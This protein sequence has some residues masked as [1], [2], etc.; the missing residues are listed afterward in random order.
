MKKILALLMACTMIFSMSVCTFAQNNDSAGSASSGEET[1][2]PNAKKIK[3][4]EDKLAELEKQNEEL[5]K[6]T[7]K[8][9][10]QIS[11]LINAVKASQNPPKP[12]G[13]GSGNDD[14]RNWQLV[15]NNAVSYGGNIVAQGG[16]VEINGGRSNVTFVLGVPDGGTL[17]SANTLAANVKGSLLNC[18]TVS[19]SVGFRTARVN[20]YMPGVVAGDTIA[21]YQVQN[22][23]WVQLPTAE[24]RKDHVVV[25]MTRYGTVAFIRVP[26]V[27]T[28]I[29]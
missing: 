16:H 7:N 20:F 17:T 6:K 4:L 19:S 5:K 2:S 14:F 15:R 11:S 22:G 3:E 28:V 13:N 27:A 9:S 23:K 25:D 29:N 21:V 1:L 26:V 10:S 24:I 8:Q 18:V 12:Q